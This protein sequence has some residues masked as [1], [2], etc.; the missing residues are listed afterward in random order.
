MN[1]LLT[2]SLTN[3]LECLDHLSLLVQGTGPGRLEEET[4][5]LIEVGVVGETVNIR[6]T[7]HTNSDSCHGATEEPSLD[8]LSKLFILG[9]DG[10]V[11]YFSSILTIYIQTMILLCLEPSWWLVSLLLIKILKIKLSLKIINLDLIPSYSFHGEDTPALLCLELS[12]NNLLLGFQQF[13]SIILNRT[14]NTNSL[15]IVFHLVNE[16]CFLRG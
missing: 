2:Y 6:S 14:E 13:T 5:L 11:E 15:K 12:R 3:G 9:W 4:V 1:H 16:K 10:K 8:Q 7:E